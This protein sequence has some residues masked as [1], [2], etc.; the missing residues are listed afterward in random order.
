LIYC[1]DNRRRPSQLG[2]PPMMR[3][4]ERA[5]SHIEASIADISLFYVRVNFVLMSHAADRA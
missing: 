1:I 5:Y 4:A 3:I 2:C